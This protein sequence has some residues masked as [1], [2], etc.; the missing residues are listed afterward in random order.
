LDITDY[1]LSDIFFFVFPA[2]FFFDAEMTK[3]PKIRETGLRPSLYKLFYQS[4][5][6]MRRQKHPQTPFANV[7]I[8]EHS[9][10][11]PLATAVLR[12]HAGY[13]GKILKTT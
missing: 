9:A 7:A 2:A 10:R 4:P 12:R 6:C 11:L 8:N 1:P 3:D 5:H 13:C